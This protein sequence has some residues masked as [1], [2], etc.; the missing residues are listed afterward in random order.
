M[1]RLQGEVEDVGETTEPEVP[2]TEST[3]QEDEV[4]EAEPEESSGGGLAVAGPGDVTAGC[5]KVDPRRNYLA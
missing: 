1:E 3:S 4:R 5:A 2:E